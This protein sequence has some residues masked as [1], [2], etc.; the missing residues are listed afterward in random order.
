MPALPA[1]GC[2]SWSKWQTAGEVPAGVDVVGIATA[3]L[4]DQPNYPPSAWLAKAGSPWPV[5]ADS[6]TYDAAHGAR[7]SSWPAFVLLDKDGKVLWRATGEIDT[8][9]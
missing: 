3:D 6:P 7:H 4:S 1:R 5:M 2:P 8:D 9:P